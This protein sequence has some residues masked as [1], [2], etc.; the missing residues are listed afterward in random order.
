MLLTVWLH[1][2]R[3]F[4][5]KRAS[6]FIWHIFDKYACM[7]W[8][9]EVHKM[10]QHRHTH[11]SPTCPLMSAIFCNAKHISKWLLIPSFSDIFMYKMSSTDYC[12]FFFLQSILP[13][14]CPSVRYIHTY[15]RYNSLLSERLSL[16]G[17]IALAMVAWSAIR[18]MY[19]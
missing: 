9:F 10:R 13:Y 5:Q 2:V 1:Y 3:H 18:T 12:P 14:V 16:L 7:K 11:H 17:A 15:I 8:M 6:W 4:Y 19:M